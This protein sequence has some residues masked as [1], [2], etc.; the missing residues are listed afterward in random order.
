M[1]PVPIS[2]LHSNS[3][4]QFTLNIN[5]ILANILQCSNL[6]K[7]QHIHLLA[8][9][10]TLVLDIISHKS[11]RCHQSRN[12]SVRC[13]YSSR[14]HSNGQL[15]LVS[16]IYGT[17]YLRLEHKIPKK[18]TYQFSFTRILFLIADFVILYN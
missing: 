3:N 9:P 7:L 8:S 17:S 16:E 15:G 1:L 10:K 6:Y 4:I 13:D 2:I 18:R 12:T 5:N 11:V 14:I